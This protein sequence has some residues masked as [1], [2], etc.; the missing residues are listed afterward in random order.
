MNPIRFFRRQAAI[1]RQGFARLNHNWVFQLANRF[2]AIS[3]LI[4]GGLFAWRYSSLPPQLPFWFSR[5]WG[6]D[7]LAAPWW[8]L[9]LPASV[10]VWHLVNSLVSIYV[11]HDH[12]IFSKILFLTSLMLSVMSMIIVA[13]VIFMVS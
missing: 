12:R 13:K 9:M 5:P 6:D 10:I 11:L 1:I 7:Q 8:L 2:I 4:T 3:T